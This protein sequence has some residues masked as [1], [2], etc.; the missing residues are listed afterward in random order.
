VRQ[1]PPSELS[2]SQASRSLARKSVLRS[3]CGRHGDFRL[4][5]AMVVEAVEPARTFR[6]AHGRGRR[7][8]RIIKVAEHASAL[9]RKGR[10]SP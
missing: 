2:E 7:R 4:V 8:L 6:E 1:Q 10:R 3:L 5:E 9:H